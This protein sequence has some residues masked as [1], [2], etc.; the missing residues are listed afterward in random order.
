MTTTIPIQTQERARVKPEYVLAPDVI[1]LPVQDGTARLLDLRGNF[2]TV[3]AIGA[4]MLNATLERGVAAAAQ[5]IAVQYGVES[6]SV[7]TDLET[8]LQELES[9][10]LVSRRHTRR[11]SHRLSAILSSLFL[12]PI[13][14]CIHHCIHCERAKAWALLALARVSFGLFGWTQTLIVWKHYCRLTHENVPVNEREEIARTVDKTVRR[15]AAR[16]VFRIECKE[17]ALSCWALARSAGVPASL[18]V[19]VCVFPLEGHCWCEFGSCIFSDDRDRCQTY[20]PV[21][22]YS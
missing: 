4:Q 13:L 18:V 7:Q 20:T 22:V 9:Q 1:L 17:R 14:S 8:F 10:R 15:A 11:V 12:V 2:Y 3:S 16:H 5:Q 6:H 21:A 19:G